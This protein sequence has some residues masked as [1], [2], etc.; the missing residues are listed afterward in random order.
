MKSKYYCPIPFH[1][2]AMRP[3]GT[4]QPC[5]Y[6]N[7]EDIPK[8]F[9][10]SYKNLFYDHPF[11]NQIREELREDRPVKG[12][13]KC[14]KAE[15]LTGKSMRTE[16]IAESRLG[17]NDTPPEEPVLTYIDLALSNVCNNR[18]RMCGFELSTNW[19]SDSKKLG[20]EIPHGLIQHKND[21]TDID[22]SKINY[23][24]MIG[25]EPLME[26]DKFIDV[27]KRCNLSSLNI[28]VTTNATVRPNDDLMFLLKQCKKVQWVLSVDSFGELNSFLRKGSVWNEVKENIHWYAKTFYK[29]V[30]VNGVVSIYN[31]NNFYEL[32]DYVTSHHPEVLVRFNMIDGVDY[33]HP[34]HLPDSAKN[35]IIEK[36]SSLKY[37][38]V[39]R[40]IDA[41]KQNGDFS[42]FFEE[43]SK[44]NELRKETWH[45][46]NP[47]LFDLIKDISL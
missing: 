26:Q 4:I 20:R 11:M 44:M 18:C 12:C 37:P 46:L 15:R 9:N 23:I 39:P 5:C 33:M 25:G 30:N 35:Y 19:Y 41:L 21:L 8:D 2:I 29:N 27:L 6:F 32:T 42:I 40:V 24:K 13:S 10:L 17:F 47:E 1:H 45:R 31:S 28:L 36:L 22:F 7:Y 43:D 38:V 3:N 34:K 14:Y 16:Y